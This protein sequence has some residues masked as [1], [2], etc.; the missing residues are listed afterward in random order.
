MIR[1]AICDDDA[2]TRAYLA[3]L[4]LA[5]PCPCEIVEYASADD[6]LADRREIDVLVGE[7]ERGISGCGPAAAATGFRDTTAHYFCNR[8]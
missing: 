8:L 4:I 7:L 3:S 6:C 5:Q 2:K 1:T